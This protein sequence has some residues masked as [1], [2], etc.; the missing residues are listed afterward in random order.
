MLVVAIIALMVASFMWAGARPARAGPAWS[1]EIGK[2]FAGD[3]APYAQA[4]VN[5]PLG[6]IP[7]IGTQFWLLPEAGVVLSD[8]AKG[9]SRVQVL[10]DTPLFTVGAD[11]KVNEWGRL[12]VR[13]NL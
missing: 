8:P 12:F 4:R 10:A 11:V 13:F 5:L 9:Y 2:E 6:E 3:Q 7:L 1:F